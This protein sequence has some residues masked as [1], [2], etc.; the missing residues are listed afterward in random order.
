MRQSLRVSLRL[1]A[2]AFSFRYL[3]MITGRILDLVI[4]ALIFAS[5]S[6]VYLFVAIFAYPN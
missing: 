2:G 4:G 6:G 3:N 5:L 1:C